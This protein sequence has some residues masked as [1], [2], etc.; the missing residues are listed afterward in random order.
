MGD[1]TDKNQFDFEI[2][3]RYG[4]K[5]AVLSGHDGAH[6]PKGHRGAPRRF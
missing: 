5:W 1:P 3:K 4:A 6:D 2:L